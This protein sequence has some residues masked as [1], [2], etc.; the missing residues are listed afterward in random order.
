MGEVGLDRELALQLVPEAE[1]LGVVALLI[2][3]GRDER[4]ER[5]ALEA[6]DEVDR[7]VAVA[8][9]EGEERREQL[10]AEAVRGQLAGDQV[11]AGDEVLEVAVADDEPLVRRA[12]PGGG[13]PRSPDVCATTPRSSSIACSARTNSPAESDLKTTPAT[14]AGLRPSSVSSVIC[15]VERA[16]SRSSFAPLSFFLP[17]RTSPRPKSRAKRLGAGPS[18]R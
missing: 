5:P 15:A 7:T 13:G 2:L 16:K 1:L 11:N 3:A 14:P 8:A 10:L 12:R 17:K 4:P 6:V 18:R 9:L